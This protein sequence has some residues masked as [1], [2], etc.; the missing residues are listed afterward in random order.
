MSCKCPTRA[1]RG[2]TNY[3]LWKV[4]ADGV[5]V[6]LTVTHLSQ[7]PAPLGWLERVEVDA[8]ARL[9]AKQHHQPTVVDKH[10]KVMPVHS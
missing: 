8:A 5:V 1:Q 10:G 3:Y 9:L 6:P 4:D 2:E 7:L